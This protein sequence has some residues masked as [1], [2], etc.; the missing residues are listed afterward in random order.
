M[1]AT[2]QNFREAWTVAKTF[3]DDADDTCLMLTIN[4]EPTVSK[5]IL[6]ISVGSVLEPFQ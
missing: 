5:Y 2:A 3:L 1:K 6:D 4:T